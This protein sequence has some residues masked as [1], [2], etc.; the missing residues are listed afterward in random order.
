MFFRGGVLE[1]VLGLGLEASSLR[2]LY[3]PRLKDSTIFEP[4]KFRW[5]TPETLRKICKDLF[6]GSSSRDRLKKIFEDFFLKLPEKNFEDLFFSRTL[7]CICVL[8]PWPREGLSLAS[9]FFCVLGLGLEPYVLDSTSGRDGADNKK[10][11]RMLHRV[12]KPYP[13]A[14]PHRTQT[15]LSSRCTAPQVMYSSNFHKHQKKL[16]L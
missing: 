3:C 14:A 15:Q 12:R 9:K 11:I 2:K 7:T 4:L 10:C 13:H 5:K 8:G 16:A 1:D 6:L